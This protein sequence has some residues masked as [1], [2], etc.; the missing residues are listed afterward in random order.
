MESSSSLSLRSNNSS[1]TTINED[2]IKQKTY[3]YIRLIYTR[4]EDDF[5]SL[6]SYNNFDP[7]DCLALI[8]KHSSNR[9]YF[10]GFSRFSISEDFHVW[11]KLKNGIWHG[12]ITVQSMIS[13]FDS[14]FIRLILDSSHVAF[15]NLEKQGHEYYTEMVSK[16]FVEQLKHTVEDDKWDFGGEKVFNRGI[17]FFTSRWQPLEAV[18]PAFPCKSSNIEKVSGELPDKGEELALKRLISFANSVKNIYPP[19][20]IVWI[21]SDGHVFSDCIGV[22]DTKVNQ[23]S[24]ALKDLYEKLK[25]A[26]W[27][28]IKFCSLP[29]IFRL[30]SSNFE[31]GLVSDVELEHHLGTE[32]DHESETCRKILVTSCDTDAGKLRRDITTEGHPRLALFRGFSK[33]MTEDLALHPNVSNMSKKKYKKIVAGVAFEMIKRND[34]YSNLVELM[35]PFHLRF[36]I[37]AHNN[38]GPK[39]G[40]SLLAKVGEEHCHPINSIE[41][42][43]EPRNTDLLHIPTPWHNAIVKIDNQETYYVIK[44][45]KVHEELKKGTGKGGWDPK[46]LHYSIMSP[47]PLQVKVS[48]LKR[49]IKEEKYYQQEVSEQEQYVSQMKAHKADEY[50]IKKQVEVLEESKRMVPQV[51]KKISEHKEAL[52]KF[53]ESYSGEEDISTAKELVV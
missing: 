42:H 17:D 27:N 15:E 5:L 47:S 16:T 23:Y 18:L 21:V 14:W 52:K 10:F 9:V 40:I 45:N 13:E 37:H 1:S 4:N 46:K 6:R 38:A 11:E 41:D 29:E 2:Q 8:N 24:Q 34:A 48:A 25:P 31:E 43:M 7:K 53:L 49:L 30:K 36:S 28:P 35:F 12:V 22:D 51:S 32:L 20:I 33:F 19:G 50:E 3:E 44:S 26:D 39:F